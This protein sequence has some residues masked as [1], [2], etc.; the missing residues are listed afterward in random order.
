MSYPFAMQDRLDEA[1]AEG[2]RDGQR[3]MMIDLEQE[4]RRAQRAEEEIERLGRERSE[5][6]YRIDGLKDSLQ[7]TL[8]IIHASVTHEAQEVHGA[9]IYTAK[10]R[11][12][13]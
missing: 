2:K 3:G 7:K 12:N 10:E 13:Q 9:E 11:L 6:Q 4:K 5:M 8:D 1:R